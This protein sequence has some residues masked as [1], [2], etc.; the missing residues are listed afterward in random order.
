MQE[1]DGGD[2][3]RPPVHARSVVHEPR[4]QGQGRLELDDE[5]LAVGREE[6]LV[7]AVAVTRLAS[8]AEVHGAEP[9]SAEHVADERGQ[10]A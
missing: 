5:G 7:E 9:A 1:P 4:G 2:L 6:V 8:D 3:R 10:P